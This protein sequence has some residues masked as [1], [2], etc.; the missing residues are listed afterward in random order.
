MLSFSFEYK[1]PYGN[2][3][4]KQ[5]KD[6]HIFY[7]IDYV[8]YYAIHIYNWFEFSNKFFLLERKATVKF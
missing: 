2:L 6:T 7:S 8:D 3:F 4:T 1:T 5:L